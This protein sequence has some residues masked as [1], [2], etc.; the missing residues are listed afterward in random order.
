MFFKHSK[1]GVSPCC[2]NANGV[3]KSFPESPVNPLYKP[4]T[5]SELKAL[6][7]HTGINPAPV[8]LRSAVPEVDGLDPMD[9]PPIPIGGDTFERIRQAKSLEKEIRDK[10][11]TYRESLKDSKPISD[12]GSASDVGNV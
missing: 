10:S 8:K 12:D 6:F 7:D 1:K 9:A 2:D 3:V 5:L 4:R 11:D